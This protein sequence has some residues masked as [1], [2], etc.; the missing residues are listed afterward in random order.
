MKPTRLD[1]RSFM[2]QGAAAGA[3]LALAPLSPAAQAAGADKDKPR[4]VR[5]GVIGCGSVSHVYLPHLAGCPHVELVS[6]CDI[7]PERAERQA[8]RFYIRQ[9]QE[10]GR[11]VPLGSTFKWPVVA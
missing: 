4:P 1:R 3:A 6:A 8:A 5:V 9:S 7:I 10:T 11:R 2:G